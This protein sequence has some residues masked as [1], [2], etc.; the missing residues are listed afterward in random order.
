MEDG[1][2]PG[3]AAAAVAVSSVVVV[4]VVV[5]CSSSVRWCCSFS[6]SL[7]CCSSS[8]S[9][10]GLYGRINCL[11]RIKSALVGGEQ[12]NSSAAADESTRLRYDESRPN[13]FERVG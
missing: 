12:I 3:A 13:T 6:S 5:W 10:S 2:E 1:D 11:S 8:S 7:V 9:S 4:V